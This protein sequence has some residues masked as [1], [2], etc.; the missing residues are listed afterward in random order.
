[1]PAMR[2]KVAALL[3]AGADPDAANHF[4]ATPM[5]RGRAYAAMPPSCELLLKAGADPESANAEG[6]TA[7]MAVARTGNIEAAKAA[8]ASHGA[9]VDAREKWGGQTALIWAA[10]QN[11]PEMVRVPRF[12]GRRG[13]CA[14]ATVRDWQRRVTAEEPPEGHEP[15]RHHRRCCMRRAKDTSKRCTR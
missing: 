8:A 7:L 4:G 12:E 3:K 14:R 5:A 6:Q 9:K 11:Q 2:T 13:R 10:A 1:M 15:R